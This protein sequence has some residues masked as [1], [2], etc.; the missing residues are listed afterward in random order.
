[1]VQRTTGFVIPKRSCRCSFLSF[2][3]PRPLV[4]HQMVKISL[5]VCCWLACIGLLA[6]CGPETEEGSNNEQQIAETQQIA[7]D[8]QARNNLDEARNRLSQLNVANPSQWLVYVTE[9]AITENVD[10]NTTTALVTLAM[11]LELQSAEITRFATDHNLLAAPP[12]QEPAVSVAPSQP[13]NPPTTTT[14]SASASQLV[15]APVAQ[16]APLTTTVV[17]TLATPPTTTVAL[18]V[19]SPTTATA[20]VAAAVDP[21]PVAK[22]KDAINVRGGPGVDYNLV[23]AMQGG[24]SAPIVSK[25]P[26]GDW[27]EVAL[28]TGQRGWVYGQLVESTGDTT[29]VAVAANIPA[30]P[31]PTATTA[32]PPPQ[33]PAAQPT[34]PSAATTPQPPPAN[35]NDTPHF[36]LV[37]KRM[38]AKSENGDCRGQHLLRLHILDANGVR[39]NGVTLQG[40]YTGEKIVT[41]S[42]G[43]GDGIIEYDLYNSGEG[44]KVVTNNDGRSATSDVADGF[45]T[46]SLDIDEATLIAGGYCS[47]HEDCQ[48]FYSSYGCQ[49]HHSWEATLKRNY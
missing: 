4:L 41:G 20:P 7:L 25:N 46:R 13:A 12:A 8:F 16:A 1:M 40:I 19:A 42:Q 5:I 49:G 18:T 23:G 14:G 45:T 29:A 31:P 28:T 33:A 38:W 6:A 44:F 43:K 22:A 24:E 30:P 47:N 26:E 35:P 9:G 39:L 27:W 3:F 37:A 10:G 34:Q 36:S 21:K 48:V 11:Q 17:L 15:V 2:P 32:A